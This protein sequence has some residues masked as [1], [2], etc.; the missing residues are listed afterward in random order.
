MKMI[1]NFFQWWS[2][3]PHFAKI[4]PHVVPRA[5][6][7]LSRMTDG[8]HT[9]S[10]MAMPMVMLHHTGAK[11]GKSYET[12]LA[13]FPYDGGWIVI[14]SNFGREKHPAWS[15]NLIAHP[16]IRANVGQGPFDARATLLDGDERQAAWDHVVERWGTFTK[17]DA[18][19]PNREIRVFLLQ[20]R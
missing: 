5:D 7:W 15:G 6:R 13:A 4:A 9:F 10:R 1:R 12:P 8:K 2:G 11:S 20:P 16:D 17:Y 3:K 14:G 19:T 18:R